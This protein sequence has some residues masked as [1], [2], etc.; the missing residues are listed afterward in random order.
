MIV[1]IPSALR[2]YTGQQGEI[3]LDCPTL[4]EALNALDRRFPGIRFRI[5][6]EQDAIRPHI[7]IFVNDE[8]TFHLFT[9][10][11]DADHVHIVCALSGG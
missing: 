8:Q 6:T 2:S 11:C 1:H 4:A 5:I 10:L 3:E 9:P 7:R